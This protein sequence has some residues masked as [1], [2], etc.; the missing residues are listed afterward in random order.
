MGHQ[1]SH[2]GTDRVYWVNPL[3]ARLP[4]PLHP[5]SLHRS[6]PARSRPG[7]R[8]TPT[9]RRP[10]HR[11][12]RSRRSIDARAKRRLH[13]CLHCAC[14]STPHRAVCTARRWPCRVQR[15]QAPQASRARRS[16][17]PARLAGRPRVRWRKCP[18]VARCAEPGRAHYR[19]GR[20]RLSGDRVARVPDDLRSWARLRYVF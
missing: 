11:A 18:R 2:R 4:P 10:V 3:L 9:P 6:S 19:R 8:A 20:T 15:P 14:P 1:L 12:V 16:V 5:H 7:W 13:S 17:P